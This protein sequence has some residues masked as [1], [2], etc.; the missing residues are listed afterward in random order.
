MVAYDYGAKFQWL[1]NWL[2][3]PDANGG[4][5]LLV[6]FFRDFELVGSQFHKVDSKASE[7]EHEKHQIFGQ[8][9]MNEIS[10]HLQEGENKEV[11]KDQVEE[12]LIKMAQDPESAWRASGIAKLLQFRIS[13]DWE[14]I[15]S[16]ASAST[17]TF[18]QSLPP[19]FYTGQ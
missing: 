8:T 18:G 5:D 11:V 1:Q 2:A 16:T 4:V 13:G 6:K 9:A 15:V 17:R 3:A 14:S 7:L 12:T 19:S 10:K